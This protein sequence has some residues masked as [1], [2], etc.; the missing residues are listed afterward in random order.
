MGAS[1]IIWLVLASLSVG[2]SLMAHGKSKKISFW[3]A[4]WRVGVT[5]LLLIWGGFFSSVEA[6]SIPAGAEQHRRTLVR[7]AHAGWGLD[8]PI[9]TMAGQVH[10][11]SAWR[12]DARSPAGAQGLAQFMPATADWMAELYPRSLGPA[13]PYNPGWALRAMVA[14]DLWLYARNQAAV[15]ECDRWAFVLAGY[16][17]GQGWVNRD[18]RLASA[19]GAD[20][21]AWFD[22]VE[23]H[24]AG[25]SAA[26]FRENRHYPRAILLRW[27]PL[28]A[29]AGWGPGVCASRYSRHEDSDSVSARHVDQQ[30]ACRLLPEL[31]GCRRAVRIATAPHS[32]GPAVAARA[33]GQTPA[34][35]ALAAA[36]AQA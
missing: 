18:R 28:Y 6:A 20:Q 26:N 12:V 25:R 5:A 24:N 11:E 9:A 29:A 13:Q 31:A 35:A 17:G 33:G 32:S 23:R 1:Q 4:L 10:Q 3:V 19:M 30:F 15:S 16:N 2:A 22:S 8:A 27:E 14:Y 34:H 7:A 21:L 36:P